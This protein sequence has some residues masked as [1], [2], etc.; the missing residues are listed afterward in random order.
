[1]KTACLL[2][3]LILLC[4]LAQPASQAAAEN[5][6]ILMQFGPSGPVRIAGQTL[7]RA[8]VEAFY[9]RRGFAPAWEDGPDALGLGPRAAVIFGTLAA[10]ADEGLDPADYHVREIAGLA[11]GADP[12]ERVARDLLITD[13]LFRYIADQS[14]SRLKLG[15]SDERPQSGP[16]AE[17]LETAA[18]LRAEALRVFLEERAPRGAEYATLKAALASARRAAAAGGWVGLPDGGT[19]RPGEH[20]T[21]V[22]ALRLRLAAEGRKIPAIRSASGFSL[23]DKA[24]A[25]A[26]AAFQRDHG[27]KGDGVIGDDTRAALNVSAQAR[28]DQLMANLERA[29][30]SPGR[31]AA[32][33]SVE[34]NIAGYWLRAYDGGQIA[35]TMPVVVGRAERKTPLIETRITNVV[36]NP[37]WTVPPTILTHD[38]LPRL[39]EN[40][41]YLSIRGLER[42]ALSDG[43]VRLVQPPGPGNPLGRYKFILPNP[44]DIYLHDSPES[45]KFRRE[46][47]TFSSGCVRVGDATSLAIFLL[48]DNPR[49]TPD[50]LADLVAAGTTRTI[51]LDEPIPVSLVYKTAWLDTHDRLILGND[52][53]DRDQRLL[54][55]LK[56]ARAPNPRAKSAEQV[57]RTSAM[58]LAE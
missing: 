9:A 47:R 41:D 11:S 27:L 45:G 12:R 4:L 58:S 44:F 26:V 21:A 34:V 52:P 14:G 54:A 22:P 16:G 18:A 32:G 13:G 49:F 29:R 33:R 7:E 55:A 25:E 8:V 5:A 46:V 35:L 43:R 42:H 2:R 3:S 31:P 23:Y 30:W 28:I 53:Y 56:K 38:I 57:A 48:S 17:V 6:A 36:V 24:L 37:S 15:W 39:E 10:A 1:L 40:A 51:T 20:D 19:I 50:R